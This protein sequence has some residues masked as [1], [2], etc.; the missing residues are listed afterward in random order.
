MLL[1]CPP[2]GQCEVGSFY[3]AGNALVAAAELMSELGNI[4]AAVP[5]YEQAHQR[6]LEASSGKEAGSAMLKCGKALEK[7]DPDRSACPPA[8]Q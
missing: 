8:R 7:T 3:N 5:T 2:L 4:D 1:A 6:F